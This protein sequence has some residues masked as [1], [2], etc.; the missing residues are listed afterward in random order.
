MENTNI[1]TCEEYVVK[2]ITD[3]EGKLEEAYNLINEQSEEIEKLDEILKLIHKRLHFKTTT[4][5]D[6]YIEFDT[7]WEDYD[8]DIYDNLLGFLN[9]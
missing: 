8:K 9:S 2:H 7:V 3:I 1:K 6:R 5:E 4:N